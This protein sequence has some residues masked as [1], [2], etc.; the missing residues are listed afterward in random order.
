MINV[1]IADDHKIVLEGLV[2]ILEDKVDINIVGQAMNGKEVYEI[3]KNREVDIAILDIE[4]PYASGV[5]I[6]EFLAKEYPDIKVIILTMY[7]SQVFVKRVIASGAKGYILKN[8]G[9]EEL[10][11]AIR[12]VY[13]GGSYIGEEITDVLLSALRV[14]EDVKMTKV[15]KL[16]KR[17]KEILKLIC[18]GLT[19]IEIGKK[20]F[21]A[22]STVDTHRR[23][24]IDKTGVSNSKKLIKY[25]FENK[26]V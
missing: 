1:I 15:V 5:E 3:I 24:L 21:I 20:L 8:R 12:S 25:A 2:S 7:K 14:N 26:L 10:T 11:K 23:N 16:T 9:G 22:S 18:D 6:T 13:N 4:M 17:E 19:S